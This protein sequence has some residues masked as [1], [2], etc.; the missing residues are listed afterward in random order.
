MNKLAIFLASAAT[1]AMQA[2]VAA[3]PLSAVLAHEVTEQS[4]DGV[5]RVTRYQERFIREGDNVWI[6]RLLPEWTR[7]EAYARKVQLDQDHNELDVH[8]APRLVR[9][10]ANGGASLL[11]VDPKR[12]ATFSAGPEDFEHLGFS[13]RWN[14]EL[15][16]IDPA[17]LGQMKRSPRPAEISGAHWYEQET[18]ADYTRILWSERLQFPLAIETGARDGRYTSRTS[19]RMASDK[20]P[21][22]PWLQLR[23]YAAREMSDLGD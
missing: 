18:A 22:R 8:V 5:T 11:L 20:T 15:S 6:E 17:S 10:A 1:I 12:R 7:G 4:A 2:A 19:V 9:P 23:D 14:A 21:R 3:P 16:L 13:G